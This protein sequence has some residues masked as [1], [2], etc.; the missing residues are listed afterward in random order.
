MYIVHVYMHIHNMQIYHAPP[1]YIRIFEM[2]Q[3]LQSLKFIKAAEEC[4]IPI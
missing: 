4:D 1:E 2:D 3:P